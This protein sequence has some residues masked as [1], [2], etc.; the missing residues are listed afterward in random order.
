MFDNIPSKRKIVYAACLLAILLCFQPA[1]PQSDDA[2]DPIK[3]F[4]RGQDAHARNDYARA[5]QLYEA[6]IKLKPEFPEAEFQR[7][8]A[9]L[10][11]KRDAEAIEGFQRAVALRPDW[12]LAYSKFGTSLGSIG[13]D[14]TPAEPIL[15][16]AIELNPKDE[17]AMAILA[18]IRARAGDLSEALKLVRAATALEAATAGTWRVR[19]SIEDAKGDKSAA[20]HSLDQALILDPKDPGARFQRA[21]LRLNAGDR[22]GAVAD[23][24]VLEQ[25]GEARSIASAFAYAQLYEVAGRTDDA[26]RVLDALPEKDRQTPE[27]IA[28]RAGITGEVGDN[29]EERAALEES[30]KK[31]PQNATLL[32]RLGAAYRRVNPLTSQD[33]YSRALKLEPRN[34]RYATGYAAALIQSRR[35]MEAEPILRQVIAQNPNDYTAHANLALALYEMKRFAEAVPEYEWLANAKPEIAATYF[36]I[37]TAHDNLGEYKQALDAYEK[38]LSHADPTN[39][40]L[41]IDKVNLRLPALRAQIQRGE[42]A[43]QKRP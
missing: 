6:A 34:A 43:K 1:F 12:A 9:L 25:A 11:M 16:R 22:E 41:E 14:P 2:S 24:A 30:L 15:R 37:A 33:Y 23:L 4:E 42:G 35:F 3:L 13:K 7:A 20:L 5:I 17:V 39:N 8:M 32:A 10:P 36:F 38:F 28:L 27:V 19:A 29:P 26:L 18:R 40:K 21:K 31:D